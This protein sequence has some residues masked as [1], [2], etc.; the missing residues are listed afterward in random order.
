MS[1][2]NLPSFFLN[3]FESDDMDDDGTHSYQ[4]KSFRLDLEERQLL[5]N[6]SP[7]PLTPK[8]FDVLATLVVRSSHLV[9]KDELLRSVW[10]ESF[11]EESNVARIVHTLRRILGEDENGNKFIETVP[12]KGYRFVADVTRVGNESSPLGVDAP[13]APLA[14]P[15][16]VPVSHSI[17]N[18]S[19]RNPR[20]VLFV[21]GF[22]TAISLIVL[23]SFDF[24]SGSSGNAPSVRSIAILPLRALNAN[25][26]NTL[27]TLGTADSL[28]N[29]LS[30]VKG[31]IVR[32][33]N[34]T[35]KYDQAEVDPVAVGEEQNVDYVL[36]SNYQIAEGQIRITS[37][38][39]NVANGRAEE[40][41]TIEKEVTKAF[42]LQNAFAVEIGNNLMSR[43][44]VRLTGDPS[45]RG[46]TNAE[47]YRLY[48]QGMTLYDR[49]SVK[50][51]RA[52]VELLDR[53]VQLD[54]TYA[55][56]WAGNAHAH[57]YLGNMNGQSDSH[58]EYKK[59]VDA[60]NRALALDPNLSEA[61]SALCENKYSY[62]YDFAGAERECKRAL[63][64]DPNSGLAH[65]IYSRLL[66]VAGRP[67]EAIAESEVAIDL[68]PISFYYKRNLGMILFTARRYDE[69]VAQFKRVLELE[70]EDGNSCQ[71]LSRIFILQGKEK[72]AFDS[73]MKFYSKTA[74]ATPEATQ[75]YDSAFQT[76]GLRG[77]QLE[78]VRRFEEGT[79]AI[80]QGATYA[81]E[82]GDRDKAFEYL[83]KSLEQR[84]VWM[85][86]LNV[87]PRLDSL[88]DDPR[89]LPLL[90]RVGPS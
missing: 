56:A 21:A 25:D 87:D 17:E 5:Q 10:G 71:W 32:S 78:R 80:Y 49:R 20:I 74:K 83:E 63:E 33:L 39:F 84:E 2:Q 13:T 37:Q 44:A 88:R 77:F 23:L 70:K 43:F 22:V 28:I 35:Q 31:F 19:K 64:L 46:A 57:R 52:S 68:E 24:Q 60:A 69:A 45:R 61:H 8:A 16:P 55:L 9:E 40:T 47:A 66:S 75:A 36:A 65:D 34:S 54:P 89:Y 62:E 18:G 7:V 82:I 85:M 3:I 67:A 26:R 41:Y 4:F 76:S 86:G 48:L 14:T 73:W 38:L 30:S 81:L 27:Y 51:A 29:R 58:E 59:S 11:V 6:G 72:E 12:T 50:N 15:E 90:A 1:L 79:Q 53:A 42:E